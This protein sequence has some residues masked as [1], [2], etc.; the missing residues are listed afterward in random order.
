MN[1]TNPIII[2]EDDADD[3][4]IIVSALKELG[5]E[6]ERK[7]FVNGKE[8]L[9]YLKASHISTFVILSDVNMPILNGLELKAAINQD[10]I[11][12]K[13]SIPFIF[14]STSNSKKEVTAA[15]DLMAQGYFK[16]PNSFDEIKD[17][18]KQ[19]VDYWDRSSHPNS[20]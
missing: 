19:V 7:C 20:N 16:K 3:C 13:Q 18:L 5:V 6:N 17:I 14:L 11:L 2:I 4:D 9:D 1:N 15:Y 8:A 12:R 10:D